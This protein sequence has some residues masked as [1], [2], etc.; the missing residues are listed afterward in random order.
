MGKFSSSSA[1]SAL[2]FYSPSICLRFGFYTPLSLAV[3]LESAVQSKSCTALRTC[4]WT[5]PSPSLPNIDSHS[6]TRKISPRACWWVFYICVGRLSCATALVCHCPRVPL[7]SCVSHTCR[8]VCAAFSLFTGLCREKKARI[9]WQLRLA[10]E[11]T[12]P[13]HSSVCSKQSS[14]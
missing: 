1:L 14:G 5:R 7:L 8:L 10:S 3:H 4:R 11:M 9:H 6:T 12:A 2:A 13:D